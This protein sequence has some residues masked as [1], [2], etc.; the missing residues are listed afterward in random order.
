MLSFAK[1]AY[2]QGQQDE[3]DRLFDKY[4]IF[5]NVA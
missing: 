4:G 3:T 2:V 5:G 1:M